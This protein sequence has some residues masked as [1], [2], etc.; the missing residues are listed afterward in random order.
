MNVK[1]SI[2]WCHDTTFKL[3][4][5]AKCDSLNP[6]ELLLYATTLCAGITIM[7]ILAKERIRPKSLEIGMSGELDTEQLSAKSIY[8]SFHIV[9]NIECNLLSEQSKISR[10]VTLAN[11]SYCGTL[12]MMRKIA[13]VSHQISIVSNETI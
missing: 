12:Q 7:S 2:E 10:A 9:Y 4:D 13:P 5:G 3:A 11:D 1:V 8:N 6:K